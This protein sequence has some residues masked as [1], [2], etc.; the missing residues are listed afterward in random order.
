MRC[1]KSTTRSRSILLFSRWHQAVRQLI[2]DCHS[3]DL[4]STGSNKQSSVEQFPNELFKDNQTWHSSVNCS[5][6]HT[7]PAS[8]NVLLSLH[9]AAQP[10]RPCSH[11]H[12]KLVPRMWQRSQLFWCKHKRLAQGHGFGV[13]KLK[14]KT[15]IPTIHSR[16]R[17]NK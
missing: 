3:M 11:V 4:T 17:E 9:A 1:D 15:W 10:G 5:L 16:V 12:S 13:T 2:R 6:T 7:R 8:A 14:C